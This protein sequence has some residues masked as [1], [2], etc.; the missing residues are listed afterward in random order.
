MGEE[1]FI[2]MHPNRSNNYCC[3]GGGGGFLQSGLK[4][5][6]LEFGR[7]KDNQISNKSQ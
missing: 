6:R 7:L 4:E 3:C 1:N 5:A 2:E